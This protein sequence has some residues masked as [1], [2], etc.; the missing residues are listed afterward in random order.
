MFYR[1]GK[2]KLAT[3]I[4]PLKELTRIVSPNTLLVDEK[5][6]ALLHHIRHSCA[7]EDARYD[8]LC[9]SL[10]HNLIHYCQSLPETSNSY[11]SQ[12]GGL[13]DY[14]LNRTD[15]A[16]TLFQQYLIM[17]STAEVSE[18][19]KLWQY[20]LLSAALL[21]GIGKLL[22]AYTINI[23]DDEGHYLKP[24]NPLLE[25]FLQSGS[26]YDYQFQKETNDDFRRRLNI[27]LARTLMPA[28]GF[29]WL[30]SNLAVLQVW[31]ALLNEDLYNAGTLGAILDRADAIAIERSLSQQYAKVL[32]IPA[33]RYGRAGTFSGGVP[34]VNHIEQQLGINFIQWLN[35]A[36]NAGIIMIN[37]APLLC[38]PGGLIMSADIFK[39]FIRDNPE[40]KNWQAIQNGFLSLGLHHKLSQHKGP[41]IFSGFSVALPNEVPVYDAHA[42]KTVTVSAVELVH[43]IQTSS[44]STLAGINAAGEWQ[45]MSASLLPR[46]TSGGIIGG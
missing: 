30:S 12:A 35:R 37:K 15:A 22:A 5:R 1:Y 33:G 14:A 3:K 34:E 19:Q 11:Y 29:A 42:G 38:V 43:Q 36:L 32:D 27:L 8:S 2:K 20:A 44:T 23:Y 46:L 26:Y 31:L 4:K 16:V 41:I 45:S 21:Q 25:H 10:V 24:W 7:L 17:D 28:S 18:E 13:L 40:Y 6:Q 9:L 39:Y